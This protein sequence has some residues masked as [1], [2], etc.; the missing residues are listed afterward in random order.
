MFCDELVAEEA[1]A[2]IPTTDRGLKIV[3]VAEAKRAHHVNTTPA[4]LGVVA[5]RK[6]AFAPPYVFML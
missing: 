2:P 6:G 1:I 5:R 3:G 4:Y